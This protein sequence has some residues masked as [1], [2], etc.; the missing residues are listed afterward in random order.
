MTPDAP[1]YW[2]YETSGL[3]ALAV[4]RYLN[5]W[6]MTPGEIMLMHDYLVQ[7]ICSP[8]WDMTEHDEDTRAELEALRIAA[9]CIQTRGDIDHWIANALDKGHDP[10]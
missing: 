7:W 2:M 6:E 8:V 5:H 4:R 1:K 3:L 9:K 10:L